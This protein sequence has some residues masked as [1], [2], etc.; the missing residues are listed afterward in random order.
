MMSKEVVGGKQWMCQLDAQ[1]NLFSDLEIVQGTEVVGK[2]QQKK[3]S[4]EEQCQHL[5]SIL[6][7]QTPE[8]Q[9]VA[10]QKFSIC[11]IHILV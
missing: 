6:T 7:P 10:A 3:E 4:C 1:P 8:V 2:S 11:C 5:Q 9:T